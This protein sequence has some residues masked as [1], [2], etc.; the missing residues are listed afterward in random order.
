[1]FI[2]NL[3]KEKNLKIIEKQKKIKLFGFSNQRNNQNFSNYETLED[4]VKKIDSQQYEYVIHVILY[5]LSN[6]LNELDRRDATFNNLQM[7]TVYIQPLPKFEQQN[8][9]ISYTNSQYTSNP[10]IV[11]LKQ[12]DHLYDPSVIIT[13]FL[14]LKQLQNL[15]YELKLPL[16]PYQYNLS[17]RLF[18][19]QMFSYICKFKFVNSSIQ[20]TYYLGDINQ[21]DSSDNV[22]A[23]QTGY[24]L[25]M[26]KMGQ[27]STS[28]TNLYDVQSY[29]GYPLE[30]GVLLKVV[31]Y[32]KDLKYINREIEILEK[33]DDNDEE[34]T[35]KFYGYIRSKDS[36]AIFVKQY[37]MSLQ[38]LYEKR[39]KVQIGPKTKIR[40]ILSLFKGVCY[41]HNKDIIHR[42]IKPANILLTD[43]NIE[44]AN[45]V[46]IDFDRSRENNMDCTSNLIGTKNYMPPVDSNQEFQYPQDQQLDF[47]QWALVSFEILTNL[48]QLRQNNQD[49]KSIFIREYLSKRLNTP[50]NPANDL[51]EIIIEILTGNCTIDKEQIMIEL[52][53][54]IYSKL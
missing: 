8:Q 7:N 53:E 51:F 49:D 33:L 43:Q 30:N 38:Q 54:N 32:S 31:S 35:I 46:I 45:L 25:Q 15:C 1:M 17:L 50:N 44:N 40:L 37:P 18:T 42:D 22:F 12:E 28:Q 26:I 4:Y 36:I 29:H 27:I 5:Q 52:L 21:K 47:W 20:F 39:P 19:S 48:T 41:L 16:H 23:M 3:I 6:L 14:C 13:H 11:F 10:L 2:N 24:E 34:I 9:N